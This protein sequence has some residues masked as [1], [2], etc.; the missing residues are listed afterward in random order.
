MLKGNGLDAS[1]SR[2]GNCH[3]N[4]VAQRFFQLPKRIRIRKK[5][6]QNRDAGRQDVFD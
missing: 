2:K 3:D 5:I 6:Y 1:M 4:A